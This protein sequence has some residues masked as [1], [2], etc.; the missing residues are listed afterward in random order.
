MLILLNIILLMLFY[1]YS[2]A[3]TNNKTELTILFQKNI[4]VLSWCSMSWFLWCFIKCLSLCCN[5]CDRA[6]LEVYLQMLKKIFRKFSCGSLFF[7]DPDQVNV[8]PVVNLFLIGSYLFSPFRGFVFLLGLFLIV[9]KTR[10]SRTAF[11]VYYLSARLTLS[12]STQNKKNFLFFL[13]WSWKADGHTI[14]TTWLRN[15]R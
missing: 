2:I 15:W 10:T 5:T 12:Y 4:T 11:V 1:I 13:T 9:P 7:A 6:R 3:I 14:L 8:V